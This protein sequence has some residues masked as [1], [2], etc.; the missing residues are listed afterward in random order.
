MAGD[1]V[2]MD[3]EAFGTFDFFYQSKFKIV[4]VQLFIRAY[5]ARDC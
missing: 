2:E 4:Q 3:A 5:G 1:G